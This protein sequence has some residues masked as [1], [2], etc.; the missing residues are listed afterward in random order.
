MALCWLVHVCLTVSG[1]SETFYC[2]PIPLDS[3]NDSIL[4]IPFRLAVTHWTNINHKT[5][6]FHWLPLICHVL[7][8][9]ILFIYIRFVEHDSMKAHWKFAVFPRICEGKTHS[10]KETA[11]TGHRIAGKLN[12]VDLWPRWHLAN[13]YWWMTSLAGINYNTGSVIDPCGSD[14]WFCVAARACFKLREN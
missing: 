14:V 12:S 4:T 13:C 9:W 7:L 1:L 6:N 2:Q 11:K 10:T 8:W 5:V 3:Q